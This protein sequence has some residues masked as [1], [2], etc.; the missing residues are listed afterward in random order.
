MVTSCLV[1][2]GIIIDV[3]NGKR[4]RR[5]FLDQLIQEGAELA[6]CSINVTEVYAG[7]KPGEE[8]KT[9]S[10]LRSL[11]YYPVTWDIAKLAGEIQNVWRQKGRTLSL[12]DATIAAVASAHELL[13][14]TGNAKDFPMHDLRL[15]V[16]P[17]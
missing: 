8:V 11:R 9:E 15:F 1:D 12:P 2:S 16:L 10:L 13:L 4:G 7:M 6:C 14:I 3:L 17:G 5:E